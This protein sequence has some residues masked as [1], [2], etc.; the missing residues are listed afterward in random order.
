MLGNIGMGEMII[1]LGLVLLLFGPR[2]LPEL[3]NSLGKSIRIF[4]QSLR[5]DSTEET[6]QINEKSEK[7]D[8]SA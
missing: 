3:A 5:E 4:K 6:R 2:R 1:I 8:K 7:S